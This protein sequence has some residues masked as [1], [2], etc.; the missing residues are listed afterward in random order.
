VHSPQFV[1]ADEPTG[2]LDS[3]N[4]AM[5][6]Q[7]FLRAAKDLGAGVLLVTHEPSVAAIADRQL[8][9]RDGLIA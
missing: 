7:L 2:A 9:M 8:A 6:L 4:A 5:V 1:F 3:A